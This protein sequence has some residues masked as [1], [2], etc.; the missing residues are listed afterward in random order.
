MA[1]GVHGLCEAAR[2]PYRGL[3]HRARISS[4]GL[5]PEGS[6]ELVWT[7]AI[8]QGARPRLATGECPWVLAGLGSDSGASGL[9]SPNIQ[10]MGRWR[11]L[12]RG[13]PCFSQWR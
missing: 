9:G 7:A 3:V 6:E 2:R 12:N 11:A 4:A 13:G 10:R 8:A 1:D 5:R